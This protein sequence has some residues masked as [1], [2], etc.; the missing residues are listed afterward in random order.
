MNYMNS[1]V[2]LGLQKGTCQK[3]KNC[4]IMNPTK[5]GLMVERKYIQ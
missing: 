4:G 5:L 2:A 3:L 1:K